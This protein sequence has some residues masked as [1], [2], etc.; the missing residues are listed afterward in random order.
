MREERKRGRKEK[1]GKRVTLN[2][3]VPFPDPVD[4]GLNW[5]D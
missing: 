3:F 2:C 1:K 4:C 5:I